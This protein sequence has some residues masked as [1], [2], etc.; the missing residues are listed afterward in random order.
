MIGGNEMLVCIECGHL[1]TEPIWWTEDHGLDGPPYERFY[2]SPCCYA[3]YA[4][5]KECSCCGEYITDKYI[6]TDDG[7]R[8]CENC[9]STYDLGEED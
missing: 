6:K 2:G 1:F 7:E 5:A 9:Y 4:E 3:N 8:Y